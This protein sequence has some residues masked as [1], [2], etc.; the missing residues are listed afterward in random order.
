VRV[1]TGRK[2]KLFKVA[3]SNGQVSLLPLER[4]L[5][6]I[7]ERVAVKASDSDGGS[8]TSTPAFKDFNNYN[9]DVHPG[10]ELIVEAKPTG[11][12]HETV[13]SVTRCCSE[14]CQV[15]RH[16]RA[17]LAKQRRALSH[18]GPHKTW[19]TRI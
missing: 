11:G 18:V 1:K 2:E 13:N 16:L 5:N 14:P 8:A 10:Q 17:P 7:F 6:V 4:D 19:D 15:C 9:M 3:T 12:R